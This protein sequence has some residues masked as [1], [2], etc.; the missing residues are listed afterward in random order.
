MRP[1]H[2]QAIVF[3]SILSLTSCVSNGKFNAMQ[4]QAQKND[5]MHTWRKRTLKACQDDNERLNK[6]KAVL[7]DQANDLNLQMN[8]TKENNPYL[9]KQLRVL[10]AFSSAQA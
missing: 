8:A 7:Q 6:Q 3:L 10:A 9:R 5:S 4:Q 1:T 2:F